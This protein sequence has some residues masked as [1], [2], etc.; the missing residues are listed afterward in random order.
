[1]VRVKVISS[2]DQELD[3]RRASARLSPPVTRDLA[4]V[5]VDASVIRID[6]HT[7]NFNRLAELHALRRIVAGA[8]DQRILEAL[9]GAASI[10]ELSVTGSAIE[11]F[12]PLR[13]LTRL[14]WMHVSVATRLRSLSGIERHP[15]LTFLEIREC[16]TVSDLEPLQNLQHLRLLTLDGRMYKPMRLDSLEPLGRLN[17]LR[18][19]RLSAVRVRDRDLSPLFGLS[20]LQWLELPRHFSPEQFAELSRHL[21]DTKGAWRRWLAR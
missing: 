20:G 16:A 9:G 1:M 4:D 13:Q 5:P 15:N 14:V 6:R 12:A 10:E 8:I 19:L 3:L 17:S 7:R 11:S 2:G 18:I 21:P